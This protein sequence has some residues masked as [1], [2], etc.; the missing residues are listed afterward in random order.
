MSAER[1]AALYQLLARAAEGVALGAESPAGPWSQDGFA[2]GDAL[3]SNRNER[4][5]IRFSVDRLRYPSSQVLDP[6]VL[7]IAPSSTNE[8]HKHAHETVF[9]VLSGEGELRVGA[10]WSPLHRG[11]VAFVP[12]WA[13]HQTRNTS[14]TE[15]L[16]VVAVTDFGL[17]GTLLGDYDRRSRGAGAASDDGEG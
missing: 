15:E 17:T 2:A 5:R 14:A 10:C 12:R 16:V 13:L 1:G 8:L 3:Y 7:R 6:R 9:V 11:H 4:L